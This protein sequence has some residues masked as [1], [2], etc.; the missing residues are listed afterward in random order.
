MRPILVVA[1]ALIA[2][3]SPA[4][5]ADL[6]RLLPAMPVQWNWTGLYWG[7]HL[8]G[9]YG[10]SSFT[11]PFGP[12]LYGDHVRTPAAMAGLQL[13]YNYQAAANWVFGVEADISALNGDGTQ[14]C[15]AA[16]GFFLSANC[17]VKHKAMATGT[18]RIG[19]VTGPGGR[20]LLYGKAGIAWL[21]QSIDLT[22]NPLGTQTSSNDGRRVSR[23][24]WCR[25]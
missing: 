12:S 8:G 18:G 23:T 17:R 22:T 6:P 16:S 24:C 21:A 7:A 10:E 14:T 1:I 9:S 19:F 11:S 15:F 2:A 13:G 5:A 20:T 25:D 4:A 3:V